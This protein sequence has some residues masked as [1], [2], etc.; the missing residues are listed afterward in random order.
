MDAIK[1]S[2]PSVEED[3]IQSIGEAEERK[4]VDDVNTSSARDNQ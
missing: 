4:T 3:R 2:N 1:F